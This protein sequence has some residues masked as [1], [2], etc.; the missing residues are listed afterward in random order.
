MRLVVGIRA[1]CGRQSFGSAGS[2]L[3][4]E[5]VPGCIAG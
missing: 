4:S 2:T 1:Q 5:V 3:A